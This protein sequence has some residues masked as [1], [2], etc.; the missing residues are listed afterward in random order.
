MHKHAGKEA[1]V[2]LFGSRLDDACVGG[3]VDVLVQTPQAPANPALLIAQI[4]AQISQALR[5]RKVDVLLCA[6]GLQQH[7]IHRIALQQGVAL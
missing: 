3:D 2:I 6:P 1:Q 4:A 5:G 7:A